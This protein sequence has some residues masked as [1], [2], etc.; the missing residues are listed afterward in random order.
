MEDC[1]WVCPYCKTRDENLEPSTTCPHCGEKL[2]KWSKN[3][4]A[5]VDIDDD[6][7]PF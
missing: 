4:Q 1:R 6:E 3:H 7:M 5:W 2:P